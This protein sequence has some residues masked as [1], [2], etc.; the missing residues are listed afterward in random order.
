MYIYFS[1]KQVFYANFTLVF[2]QVSYTSKKISEFI[3]IT[4]AWENKL[5][6]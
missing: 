6:L 4:V 2:V 5:D 1:D 3:F